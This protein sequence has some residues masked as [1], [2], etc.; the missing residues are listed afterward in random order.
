VKRL[1]GRLA[2]YVELAARG[3]EH[4]TGNP[5]GDST[6]QMMQK[7]VLSQQQPPYPR[8]VSAPDDMGLADRPDSLLVA[9]RDLCNRLARQLRSRR[10]DEQ[11]NFFEFLFHVGSAAQRIG[12]Q[13]QAR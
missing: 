7:P 2:E 5:E 4:R 11:C 6:L 13:L 9:P 3:D 1:A 8:C 12:A 10:R